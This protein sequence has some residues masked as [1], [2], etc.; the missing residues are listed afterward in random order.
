MQQ[1]EYLILD[2]DTGM[3][4]GRLRAGSGT[5]ASQPR[6]QVADFGPRGA[7]VYIEQPEP[8]TVRAEAVRMPDGGAGLLVYGDQLRALCAMAA[9]R[10]L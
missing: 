5:D 1:T 10:P 4:V 3:P 6:V 2:A 9:F 8:F 7:S